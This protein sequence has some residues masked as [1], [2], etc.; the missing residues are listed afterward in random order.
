VLACG[1]GGPNELVDERLEEEEEEEENVIKG[2][3]GKNQKKTRG[4]LL[5]YALSLLFSLS[6]LSRLYQ[7]RFPARPKPLASS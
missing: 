3:Y 2:H 4:S 5:Y 1:S 6:F 7:L